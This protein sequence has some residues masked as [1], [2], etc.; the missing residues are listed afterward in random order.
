MK[1]ENI[2]FSRTIKRKESQEKQLSERLKQEEIDHKQTKE[3][4]TTERQI[5]T[6]Y[7]QK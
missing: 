7:V 5:L 1:T 2:N 3:A 6:A 4:L